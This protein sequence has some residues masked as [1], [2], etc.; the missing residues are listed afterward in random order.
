MG[1]ENFVILNPKDNNRDLRI[2]CVGQQGQIIELALLRPGQSYRP[3]KSDIRI[4]EVKRPVLLE[5]EAD[6]SYAIRAA[7]PSRK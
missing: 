2:S 7:P 6:G 1:S 5:L 3:E 4:T